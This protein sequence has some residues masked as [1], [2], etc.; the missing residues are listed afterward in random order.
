MWVS[1]ASALYNLYKTLPV[2]SA[3][4]FVHNFGI[5]CITLHTLH[6]LH[7]FAKDDL[8]YLLNR[9]IVIGIIC[10]DIVVD[11]DKAKRSHINIIYQ[12]GNLNPRCL[13]WLESHEVK[14]TGGFACTV[15]GTVS[16]GTRQ[17]FPMIH[18]LELLMSLVL[19]C[20][21]SAQS[22]GAVKPNSGW[23]KLTSNT[24]CVT[25]CV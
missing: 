17:N 13:S 2:G 7:N 15:E 1:P 18:W 20:S 19:S 16:T 6:T 25:V 3:R 23:C 4:S 21:W 12:I 8:Y 14:S 5:F 24:Q 11:H 10:W 9:Q 22:R